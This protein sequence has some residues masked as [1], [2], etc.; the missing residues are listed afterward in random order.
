MHQKVQRCLA[1]VDNDFRS[2]QRSAA[3]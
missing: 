2:R 3:A 1:F